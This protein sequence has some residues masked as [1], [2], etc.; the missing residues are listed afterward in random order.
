ML[1]QCFFS[2]KW[3]DNE[4][5]V[6]IKVKMPKAIKYIKLLQKVLNSKF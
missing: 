3:A 6:E 1:F 5:H 4:V 2:E